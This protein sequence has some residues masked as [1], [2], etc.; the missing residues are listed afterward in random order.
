MSKKNYDEISNMILTYVGGK[1]NISYFTHCITRL[2]FTVRD[3][4]I[5]NIEEIKKIK[6]LLGVQWSGEQLQVIVGDDVND[7][8]EV[9]CE[10]TGIAK[11]EMIMGEENSSRKKWSPSVLFETLSGCMVPIL[12]ALCAAGVIKGVLVML[13]TYL[14]M[15]TESGIYTLLNTI[16]DV[17]FYF[18]PFM[19]AYSSAKKFKTNVIAAMLLAGVYLHPSINS[20]AGTEL[21]VLGINIH[22][23]NYSSTVF[24]I[25]V[26]VWLMSYVYRFIDKHLPKP[27]RFVLSTSLT[28]LIMSPICLAVV[29]PIGYYIGYYL[30]SFVSNLFYISPYIGGFVLGVI[31]PFVLL[32]GMQTT[33]T[34]IIINN[35]TTLGY[36]FIWP[37]HQTFAMCCCG[38][39]I[40]AYLKARRVKGEIGAEKENFLSA[41][42]S[43]FA[44]VSEPAL[45]GNAFRFKTQLV[46]LILS[47]GICG[48]LTGGFGGKAYAAG[49]PAWL[50]LPTFGET[51]GIMGIMFVCSF[52]LSM[53]MAYIAGFSNFGFKKKGE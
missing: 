1:E 29:G 7:V 35:L 37:V 39:S 48:A 18:M 2:R 12:P 51:A 32:T 26:S 22:I 4:S 8:Y 23:L 24:P 33:F 34:P 41:F 19:V 43:G 14:G 3:K 13:T 5:V 44:G 52:I 47:S 53:V 10:K 28:L 9:I 25:I 17:A 50:F 42:V 21:N 46:A 16:G 38:L 36:D 45:Y 15:S 40:G 6:S 30:A 27:L 31:R 49:N 20:L 11:E